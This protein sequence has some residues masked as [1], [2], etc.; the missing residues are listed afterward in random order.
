MATVFALADNLGFARSAEQERQAVIQIVAQIQRADY[1]GNRTA[2]ERL[3]GDLGSVQDEK[4]L[5][6]RVSYWRGFALWRRALNFFN[7]SVP[8]E[9][10]R[11]DLELAVTEF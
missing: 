3:Y 6:A 1:E 8:T 10:L 9:E 5:V 7:E 11:H 4:Q 2:L